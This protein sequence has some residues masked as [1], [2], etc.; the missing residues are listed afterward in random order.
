M[1]DA[2]AMQ[3][4]FSERPNVLSEMRG[5][6]ARRF[7]GKRIPD[8]RPEESLLQFLVGILIQS[9]TLRVSIVRLLKYEH[10]HSH[11]LLVTI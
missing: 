8:K 9:F 4:V 10:Q 5:C 11:Y 6:P 2:T 1:L 3:C 7:L